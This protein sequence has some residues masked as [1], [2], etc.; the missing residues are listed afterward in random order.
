[1]D[2]LLPARPE[3]ARFDEALGAWVLSRYR[4]VV[5]AFHEPR[6][7]TEGKDITRLRPSSSQ[8]P[9]WQAQFTTIAQQ[10][11]GGLPG[12]RPVDMVA[13]FARPWSLSAA[14]IVTG[15]DPADAE[16]LADLA[17]HISAAAAEPKDPVLRSR[18][19]EANAELEKSFQNPDM[20]LGSP[21]FVA[22]SQTL[23]CLLANAWLALLR[24][25]TELARLRAAPDLMPGAIEELL[26]YAGLAQ[27]VR[28]RASVALD[29]AGVS[30]AEGEQV[31]LMLPSANRDP[32]Q[33][34]DP[35]RLDLTRSATGQV[36][37]GGGAHSCVGGP[38]IRMAMGVATSAFVTKFSG[39]ATNG[40]VEWRGGS[41]FR[42]PSSLYVMLRAGGS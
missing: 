23:P 13:E 38:L 6:L 19:A 9:E 37:L 42:S 36:A 17:H 15:I 32:A 33:F 1:M 40:E 10:L 39:D 31:I 20:H 7:R 34:P 18:A 41:G 25:P 12:D 24:H 16:R 14:V 8:L 28:R 21:A 35:D 11:I 29:L 2:P 27:T 26:R 30:I 4:D 3:A 5:D 22:L